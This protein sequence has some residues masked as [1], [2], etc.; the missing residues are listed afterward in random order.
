M[1]ISKSTAKRVGGIQVCWRIQLTLSC[2]LLNSSNFHKNFSKACTKKS[3]NFSSR[4]EFSCKYFSKAC[5]KKTKIFLSSKKISH[6]K[7]V[8]KTKTFCFLTEEFSSKI[9]CTFNM[10]FVHRF[11]SNKNKTLAIKCNCLYLALK[12]STASGRQWPPRSGSFFKQQI[13]QIWIFL[14]NFLGLN[15]LNFAKE[16]YFFLRGFFYLVWFRIWTFPEIFEIGFYFW[17]GIFFKT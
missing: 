7:F 13:F 10:W 4:K 6:Q 3:K 14:E 15:F 9:L 1:K 16:F 5:A 2:H 11:F 17:E 8:R 12:R